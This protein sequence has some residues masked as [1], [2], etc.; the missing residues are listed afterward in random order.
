MALFGLHSAFVYPTFQGG[1]NPEKLPFA[2]LPYGWRV[3]RGPAEVGGTHGNVKV[4][5]GECPVTLPRPSHDSPGRPQS[6]WLIQLRLQGCVEEFLARLC[7]LAGF[8]RR[9]RILRSPLCF[10]VFVALGGF[11]RP[12]CVLHSAFC[13]HL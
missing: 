11:A 6:V 4:I 10:R 1:P 3:L 7:G 13:F 2:G 12:F 9:F 5:H 8:A